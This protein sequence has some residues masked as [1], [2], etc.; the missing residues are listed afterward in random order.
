MAATGTAA[1][2]ATGRFLILLLLGLTAPAAALAGYI[3]VGSGR[4][5]K[6]SVFHPPWERGLWAG[7]L[8]ARARGE[9]VVRRC[10]GSGTPFPPPLLGAVLSRG[11]R[12]ASAAAE[13]K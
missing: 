12:A 1:A 6:R 9:V 5:P 7:G 13:A 11:G 3:E 8:G 10:G 4:T 2:V